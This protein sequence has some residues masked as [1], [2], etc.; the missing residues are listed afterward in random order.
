MAQR[1]NN[2]DQFS[3]F[4]TSVTQDK[5]VPKVV[6]N[7]LNGNVL[8]LRFLQNP[9]PWGSGHLL[10]VPIK[11]Q[12]SSAGGSY[13]GFDSFSTSQQNTRTWA[14]FDP[15]QNYFSVVLS[16]IQRAVNKGDAAVLDLL[17]TEM[18]SVADDMADGLGTQMYSDGS[19]NSYK[20][21]QGLAAIINDGTDT[22]TY[23][24]LSRSTYT[25]WLSDEDA[26]SEAITLADLRASYDAAT[27]GTDHPTI[28]VTTPAIWTTYEGLLSATINYHSQVQGYPKM[29]RFGIKRDAGTGQTGDVGFDT[30]FFR[31]IPLVADEKCT[32]GYVW[33]INEKHL[34]FSTLAHPDFP[35]REKGFA[36][37]GL[38]RPTN[39]DASVGQFL[40]YGN[41]AAD[42]CRTHA[43]QKAKT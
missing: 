41:M 17:A 14:T 37:T 24:G 39:Q 22:A 19:G 7:V 20:D 38:Q 27:H 23:G 16:G 9:R 43:Y 40:L 1:S 29:T 30:L 42:S 28:I 13:S 6:D 35:V 25:T 8:C 15:K 2:A 34:W 12:T 33:L 26:D 36:W 21:I 5:Y 32:T 18:S 11:Y 31:G 3:S 10:R 4:V